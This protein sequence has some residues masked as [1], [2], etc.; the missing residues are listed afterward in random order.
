MVMSAG[1][2]L[3]PAP[4]RTPLPYGLLTVAQTP[5]DSDQHWRMGVRYEPDACTPDE[6]TV[7]VCPATGS[8]ELKEPTGVWSTRAANAFTLYA[9][10]VCGP[11]GN[12][13]DYEEKVTRAFDSG[14][15]RALEFEFWTGTRGTIPHLAANAAVTGTGFD[16]NVV[17]QTAAVVVTGA[18]VDIVEGIGL[19]EQS[20]ADC[21]GHEGVIHVPQIALSHL[22]ENNLAERE[23]DFLRSPAGHKIAAGSGYPGTAP[24]GTAPSAG[25]YWLYA[26]GAVFVR[27]T[28]IEI[29]SNKVQALDR[30]VNDVYLVAERT[31][32]LGWDCCHFAVPVR[33]GGDTSGAVGT[34]T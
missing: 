26:T 5:D 29:T 34:A 13:N 11:V 30:R 6:V 27:R 31:Y 17:E 9:M 22:K 28:P 24:D 19:L 20:L 16:A 1:R 3:V 7:E 32:V 18:P 4:T 2:L 10:P 12:W 25:V 14:E 8:P 23:G 33:F 15:A 21:Y